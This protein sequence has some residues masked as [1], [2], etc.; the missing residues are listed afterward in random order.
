MPSATNAVPDH[1]VNSLIFNAAVHYAERTHVFKT[2]SLSGT[3]GKKQMGR[4][5]VLNLGVFYA[6]L[7][8]KDPVN[9]IYF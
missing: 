7:L 8:L 5:V 6:V 3:D 2:Q 4:Y 1:G 9:S